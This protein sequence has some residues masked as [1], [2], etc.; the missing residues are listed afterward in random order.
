MWITKG[1]DRRKHTVRSFG[2]SEGRTSPE[3][4][5][6][7]AWSHHLFVFSYSDM[8]ILHRKPEV[9]CLFAS[10]TSKADEEACFALCTA[11]LLTPW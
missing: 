9:S 4:H 11:G 8:L 7:T 3:Q 6:A 5:S 2:G 1:I 10:K